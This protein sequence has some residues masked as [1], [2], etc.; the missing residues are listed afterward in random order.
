MRLD[1]F[2]DD[3]VA[4]H[5]RVLRKAAEQARH[6]G[7]RGPGWWRLPLSMS[8][9]VESHRVVPSVASR[10]LGCRRLLAC[11]NASGHAAVGHA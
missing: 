4:V 10:R 5:Q 3:L 1:P 2:L 8:A 6:P 7:A 9:V 11:R